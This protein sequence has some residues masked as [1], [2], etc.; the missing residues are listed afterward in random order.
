MFQSARCR[1]ENTS[2]L[3]YSIYHFTLEQSRH[4]NEE[5]STLPYFKIV[6]KNE[7][8]DITLGTYKTVPTKP[9]STLVKGL[10]FR[11]SARYCDAV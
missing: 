4:N 5:S 2:K 9:L 10:I 7:E 3:I 8:K 6:V 11:L 1:L